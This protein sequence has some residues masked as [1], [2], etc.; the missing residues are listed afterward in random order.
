MSDTD[1]L[2]I[3]VDDFE[4][5]IKPSETYND[6]VNKSKVSNP[7]SQIDT[8]F[9]YG[10]QST[11]WEALSMINNNPFA[12]KS[13]NAITITD[14]QAVQNSRSITVSVNTGVST[15][16]AVFAIFTRILTSLLLTVSLLTVFLC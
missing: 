3:V 1:Q 5:T 12:Y 2:Q 10:T 14:V 4:E 15:R 6:A 8:D 9:E 13:E 11:K 7:Q 16:P